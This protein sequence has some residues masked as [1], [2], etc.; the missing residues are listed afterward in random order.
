MF[1]LKKQNKRFLLGL[2]ALMVAVAMVSIGVTLAVDPVTAYETNVVVIGNVDIKLNDDYIGNGKSTP[3]VFNPGATVD[4]T[5]SVTNTGNNP[6]Y[7]RVLVK[8]SWKDKDERDISSYITLG[9][10]KNYWYTDGETT[11]VDEE[12]YVIYY[13]KDI[14]PSSGTEAERTTVPL[15]ETFKIQDYS[16][17]IDKVGNTTG[18]IKVMAQAVQSENATKPF[19][20]NPLGAV[21]KDSLPNWGENPDIYVVKWNYVFD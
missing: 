7:V 8:T 20:T 18:S 17:E 5:V 2:C 3:P 21:Q 13:Y 12:T 19:V 15:F 11:T 1:A 16:N 6:C 14:V 4:K 9:I 10:N